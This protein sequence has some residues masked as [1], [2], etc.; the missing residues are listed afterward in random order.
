MMVY[1]SQKNFYFSKIE[2]ELKMLIKTSNNENS[3]NKP[4]KTINQLYNECMKNLFCFNGYWSKRKIFF[5]QIK[6]Y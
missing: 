5:P 4:K 1:Y 2:E 6:I 3:F